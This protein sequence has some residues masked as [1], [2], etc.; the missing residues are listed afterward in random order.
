[1]NELRQRVGGDPVL[2][3]LGLIVKVRNGKA[4]PRMILDTKASG[5]KYVTG[6]SQRVTLPRLFDAVLRLLC[7]LSLVTTS[8]EGVSAFV[9]DF[10]DAFWQIP[11]AEDELR[12]FCVTSIIQNIRKFMVLLRA[13]QGSRAA[14]LLWA[15]L[16]ALLMRLTQSLF[17]PSQ[18]NLM[19]FVDDPIAALMGT[20]LE[21]RTAVAIIILVW[22]AL[23]FKLA[24]HKGQLSKVVTWIGG[25]LTCEALGVRA[26]VKEAIVEDVKSDLLRILRLS[27]G[28]ALAGRQACTLCWPLNNYEAVPS[29]VVGGLICRRAHWCTTKHH[30][31]QADPRHATMAKRVFQWKYWGCGALFPARCLSS[32]WAHGGNR[33]GCLTVGHGRLAGSRWNSNPLLRHSHH[34]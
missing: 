33:H 11:I 8:D 17:T 18:V 6:K 31:D 28:V 34:C 3:K 10:S 30:L 24:Y 23:D 27:Q 7:L 25:T 9:L 22:E 29:A 20:E 2:S 16:A 5:I 4:K 14:P 32:P 12:F 26:R 19:C 1:M 21:R 15:R 13:A